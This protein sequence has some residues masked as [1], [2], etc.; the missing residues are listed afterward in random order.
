LS[1]KIIIALFFSAIILFMAG[2]L[3]IDHYMNLAPPMKDLSEGVF[4]HVFATR[5]PELQKEL[6]HLYDEKCLP[7]QL[8][9]KFKIP[10]E[11]N[12]AI[13]LQELWESEEHKKL[14]DASYDIYEKLPYN[15]SL[16]EDFK[17]IDNIKKLKLKKLKLKKK[18]D[19]VCPEK[20]KFF[21]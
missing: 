5:D 15:T 1:N 10:D 17:N 8:T 13:G 4:P 18:L 9:R 11:D 16:T 3:V 2:Y 14:S 21:K 7:K 12:M 19:R 6:K 20:S